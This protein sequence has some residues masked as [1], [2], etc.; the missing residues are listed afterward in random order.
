[1]N[2][3]RNAT[4]NRGNGGFTET[5]IVAGEVAVRAV[6]AEASNLVD[7]GGV[8]AGRNETLVKIWRPVFNSFHQNG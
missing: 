2:T 4:F 6:A 3:L 5:G 7:A 8:D 1:M